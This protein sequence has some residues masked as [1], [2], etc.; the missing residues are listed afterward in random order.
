VDSAHSI[1]RQRSINYFYCDQLFFNP[2]AEY[3]VKTKVIVADF[4]SG[5]I[6]YEK[7]EQQLADIPIG[8][9]GE[10]YFS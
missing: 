2:G 1:G 4:S 8:I 5:A 3:D 9:L 7:L 6:I 10:F